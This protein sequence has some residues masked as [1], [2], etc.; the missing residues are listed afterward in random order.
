MV[1]D[2]IIRGGWIVDGTGA[3]R[4]KGDVGIVGDEIV[5]IGDLSG[6]E[7]EDIV[8]AAGKAVCPGFID[9]HVHSELALLG[10]PDRYA[11]LRMGVTTQLASPDGFS[12]APLDRTRLGEMKQY[13]RPFYEDGFIEEG[14]DLSLDDF[15]ALFRG[16]LPSNLVL[17]APHGSVRQAVLGWETRAATDEEIGRMDR[18]VREWMERGAKALAT[19]LEYEPMRRADLRELVALSRAAAAY[20]GIY[21]AHQRGYADKVTIGCEETFAIGLQADI[22]VHISHLTVDPAAASELDRGGKLGADISFDMYPYPAGSTHLLLNLPEAAQ[23]GT[24]KQ[25]RERLADPA[26]RKRIE[27]E[28]ERAFPEERIRFASVGR[29]RSDWEQGQIVIGSSPPDWLT[30]ATTWEGK[31]LGE[32]RRELGIGLTDFIC[33]LIVHT[34]YPSLMIFHWPEERYPYLEPTF[35]HPLHMVGTDGIYAGAKPHPRGF[36]S[37]PNIFRRIVREN[38]W[39]TLE[40]AVRKMT[41]YPA[42]RFGI[43][44]RGKL[45]PGL[46]ADIVVFDETEIRDRATFAEPRLAPEGVEHV[47][48]NGRFAIRDGVIQ[49]GLHGR[50]VE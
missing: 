28:V 24:P 7:A 43:K 46:Y 38:G 27:A 9:V 21:V 41:A 2:R 6:A 16:N 47:L 4:R 10:G 42:E 50:I 18:L 31:L 40:Q 45:A 3:G 22:P 5:A 37:Y 19:G 49:Q 48:V 34:E 17:Q 14:R 44:R 39:L 33:D 32:V 26:F 11:P 12:W 8:D 20:G 35:K 25:V 1:F 36:G 29:V 13:L 23:A 30:D 15:L